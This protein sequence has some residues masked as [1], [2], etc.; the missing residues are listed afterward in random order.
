M[1]LAAA[2]AER[3][4]GNPALEA[5]LT[6][7]AHRVDAV[8]AELAGRADAAGQAELS[9][10]VAELAERPDGDPAVAEH[11]QEIHRPP[12]G[13]R[14]E[15]A[16]RPRRLPHASRSSRRSWRRRPRRPP[17][18]TAADPRVDALQ[19]TVADLAARLEALGE[20]PAGEAVPA[21]LDQRL[22]AAIHLSQSLTD[23]LHRATS[24]WDEAQRALEAR[25]EWLAA[26]VEAD[27][28]APVVSAPAEGRSASG[29]VA[30]RRATPTWSACGWRSS[31]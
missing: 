25:I 5:R 14:R 13:G 16:R 21:D 28:P 19:S 15:A 26:R 11:V 31:G 30:P 7:T 23:Q 1:R 17:A 8:A 18:E 9:R 2:L 20:L 6:E 4:Q 22:A 3:P 24:S 10:L 29:A 27:A 12:G